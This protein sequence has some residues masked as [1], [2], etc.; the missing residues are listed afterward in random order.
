MEMTTIQ[1]TKE[2]EE[3]LRELKIHPSQPIREVIETIL[4][5]EEREELIDT[6]IEKHAELC[7]KLSDSYRAKKVK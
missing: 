6:I 4:D 3:R 7:T 1:I 5:K 2:D